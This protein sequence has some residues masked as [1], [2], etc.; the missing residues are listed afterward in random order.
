MIRDESHEEVPLKNCFYWVS[1]DSLFHFLH[2][3]CQLELCWFILLQIFKCMV[4][5]VIFTMNQYFKYIWIV[6][7]FQCNY[8]NSDLYIMFRFSGLANNYV[9]WPTFD[10]LIS[11]SGGNSRSWWV[12]AFSPCSL[13]AWCSTPE[14]SPWQPT[15]C[16]LRS[17]LCI[18]TPC[19]PLLT[20][21]KISL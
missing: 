10:L 12:M 5:W 20:W 8:N 11:W 13:N 6:V 2:V 18:R 1:R 17:V 21:L 7:V 15:T 16:C 19:R 9:Y 14:S 3:K 4:F